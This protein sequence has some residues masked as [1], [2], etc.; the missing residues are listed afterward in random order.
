MAKKKNEEELVVCP[1]G[2]FFLDMEQACKGK[3]EIMDHLNRSRIELLKAV[4]SFVD[5]RIEDLEGRQSRTGKK[6]ADKIKVE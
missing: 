1:V 3:S 5:G 6:K 2:R 4:K